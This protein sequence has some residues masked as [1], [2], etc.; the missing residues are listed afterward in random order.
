MAADLL[1]ITVDRAAGGP[2]RASKTEQDNLCP[3]GRHRVHAAANA[4]GP[5]RELSPEDRAQLVEMLCDIAEVAAHAPAAVDFHGSGL[6]SLRVGPSRVL[7][8]VDARSRIV[9]HHV[10]IAEALPRIA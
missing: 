3:D 8:S 5:L 1:P 7:Y 2:L 4:A 6:L 10:V 9:V